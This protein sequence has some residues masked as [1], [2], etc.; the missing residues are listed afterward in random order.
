MALIDGLVAYYRL[1]GNSNDLKGSNNG[2]DTAITY[3][4][5]NGKI[6]QGAGFNG[7]TSQIALPNLGISGGSART[8]S[9]WASTTNVSALQTLYGS[10]TQTTEAA[11]N[12]YIGQAAGNIYQSFNGN[13]YY[14]GNVLSINTFYH[15]VLVYDGGILSTS[16]VHIYLNGTAQTLTKVGGGTGAANTTSSTSGIGYDATVAGRILTGAEDEVA[17]WSRALSATEVS[18]LYNAGLGN[19]W[20]FNTGASFF[21]NM[22]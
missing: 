12:L 16:T 22:L 1:E 18:Q 4:V 17:I 8:I 20:P 6:G 7:T 10:G 13:D 19:T 9:C 3:S 15:I 2:T 11:C 14:T 21:L 5:A